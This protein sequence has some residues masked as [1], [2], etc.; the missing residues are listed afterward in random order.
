MEVEA[1]LA[2]RHRVMLICLQGIGQLQAPSKSS[3]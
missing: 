3:M 1:R 2:L